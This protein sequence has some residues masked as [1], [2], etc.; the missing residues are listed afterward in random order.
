MTSVQRNAISP[1]NMFALCS[2][3]TI[4]YFL[5]YEG[6]RRSCQRYY[7]IAEDDIISFLWPTSST[8]LVSGH[9]NH[10]TPILL[11][12][13]HNCLSMVAWSSNLISLLM[14]SFH[15]EIFFH[16]FQNII[17]NMTDNSKILSRKKKLMVHN[18]S[19]KF[20]RKAYVFARAPKSGTLF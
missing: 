7:L 8:R 19:N 11:W 16:H 1:G 15:R 20:K 5:S 13:V 2:E 12:E 18:Y 10:C 9:T 14:I 6:Y 4:C 17:A 3:K